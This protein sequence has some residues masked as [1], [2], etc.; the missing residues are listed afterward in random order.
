LVV[1]DGYCVGISG[2]RGP[3]LKLDRQAG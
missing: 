2:Q 1:D 3:D